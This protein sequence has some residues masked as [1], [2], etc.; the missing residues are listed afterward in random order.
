MPSITFNRFE[1]GLDLRQGTTVADANRLRV[2]KNAYVT[3]G[4]AIKKR[5]GLVKIYELEALCWNGVA[6]DPTYFAKPSTV[7][8]P[9]HVR[10]RSIGL[11]VG[12]GKLNTFSPYA[13]VYVDPLYVDFNTLHPT[14][15]TMLLEKIWFCDTYG[16]YIFNVCQF[17]DGTT[18]DI[19]YRYHDTPTGGN[20]QTVDANCPKTKQVVKVGE[21]MLA[22]ANSGQ[23]VKFCATAAVYDW[24]TANDAGFLNTADRTNGSRDAT[25]LGV[26]GQRLAVFSADSVQIWTIDPDP[27]NNK[28]DDVLDI[29]TIHPYAHAN[30]GGDLFFLS[31]KG[32]RSISQFTNNA[33]NLADVDVGSPVDTLITSL[34]GSNSPR[35]LYYRAGGQFWLYYGTKALVYTFSRSSKI[36]AWSVYEYPI[37]LEYITE[38]SG[39]LYVRSGDFVYQLDETAY[40]DDGASINVEIELPFLDF[41]MAGVLKQIMSMDVVFS[42]TATVQHRFD[43][44]EPS[45]IT[46]TLSLT[47]DSRS[48]RLIPVELLAT[49][50][51]PVIKH[52]GNEAFELQ[53][54]T[55]YFESLGITP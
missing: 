31:K 37:N 4:K 12:L 45:V 5:P 17:S 22:V 50:L 25:A 21:K 23:S 14:S 2:L 16:G 41:K 8:N 18:T 9:V 52:T 55:Y 34:F 3:T 53:A 42:G 26:F 39:E 7:A 20:I 36:S 32:V 6:L 43:P 27:A 47:G 40:T 49:S 33:G 38:L 54:L 15:G 1:G 30:M 35:A 44:Q 11:F 46:A 28:L 29:G 10:G 24:T 13:I 19:F 48:R 51:A